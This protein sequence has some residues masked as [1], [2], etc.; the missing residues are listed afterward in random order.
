M[1]TVYT[2]SIFSKPVEKNQ[3]KPGVH[4][5]WSGSVVLGVC[6]STCSSSPEVLVTKDRGDDENLVLVPDTRS[7]AVVKSSEHGVTSSV[8][9]GNH[10]WSTSTLLRFPLRLYSDSKLQFILYIHAL[11]KTSVKKFCYIGKIS[12]SMLGNHLWFFFLYPS[13]HSLPHSLIHSFLHTLI[14]LLIHYC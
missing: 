10:F 6:N 2:N 3:N 8:T 14:Y 4:F 12:K 9:S 13:P 1:A 11:N 7:L 5:Y